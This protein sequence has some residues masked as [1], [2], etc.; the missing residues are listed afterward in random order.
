MRFTLIVLLAGAAWSQEPA[1]R[2]RADS[3][4]VELT[5]VVQ[6]SKGRPVTDLTKDDFT[7]A[8]DGKPQTISVFEA[9]NG[10][11][12]G[13]PAAGSLPA[14]Y[15]SNRLEHRGG[16][17]ASATVLLID[18]I[19]TP[20]EFDYWGRA[21]PHLA[22][23]L[24][25]ADPQLRMAIYV[26]SRNR[27]RVVHDF[28]SDASIL[29]KELT[30][31][32]DGGPRGM[33]P[34]MLAFMTSIGDPDAGAQAVLGHGNGMDAAAALIAWSARLEKAFYGPMD[35]LEAAEAFA[36]IAQRLS[37]I[38]GRKNL[39][40]LST[41]FKRTSD[42]GLGRVNAAFENSIRALS[43]ANVAVY[44]VDVRGFV[45]LTDTMIDIEPTR[46]IMRPAKERAVRFETGPTPQ[47]ITMKELAVR[48]GGRLFQG[49]EIDQAMPLIF[50]HARSFYTLAYYPT[51]SS[52]DGKF[53]PIRVKVRR[54]G[55]KATHRTGYYAL[56]QGEAG[57]AQRKAD[58]AAA[59]WSPVD[60]TAVG[61][62]ASLES[63]SGARTLALAIDGK[64][65][66]FESRGANL[67]ARMDL[68]VVQKN[69]EGKQIESTLDTFETTASPEK[70]A[71][72]AQRGL[73]HRKAVT[74]KPDAAI[75]RVVLRNPSGAL[76]SLSIPLIQSRP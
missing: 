26:L 16:A 43:N 27:L 8:D 65:L 58:V 17:P 71:E 69:A 48:T 4:L 50:D 72:V 41:G 23:F 14:G 2:I 54:S 34:E 11:E 47:S 22:K 5:V 20:P 31:T 75:L 35:G 3:R 51:D 52:L 15:F 63:N 18:L 42:S 33:T 49:E 76:G 62:Q 56:A 45:A 59:V 1:L 74:L 40:W 25:Q 70:A 57:E 13:L 21:R 9:H 46:A 73:V 19:N 44:P 67:A 39:V 29:A 38:P 64:A 60:A 10:P 7:L 24:R 66:Q 36:A 55:A 53:R 30:T 28:T 61:F 68:L 12:V 6:D 32:A 37:G